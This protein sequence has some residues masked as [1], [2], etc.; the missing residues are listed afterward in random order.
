M[1]VLKPSGNNKGFS[2]LEMLVATSILGIAL[3]TLYVA[4]S[5]ATRN[6]RADERYAYG[7]ELAQSLLAEYSVVSADGMT[8]GGV[9][10]GGFRW[11]VSASPADTGRSG[12]PRGT[13]Q[14]IDVVVAWS[15]GL[16]D[17]EVTLHSVVEGIVS[18]DQL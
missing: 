1:A 7:V 9:T 8:D 15:D 2:L 4:A 3:S 17:R 6:V 18:S 5:S 10:A 14:S 11:T 13:L 12:L 16:K